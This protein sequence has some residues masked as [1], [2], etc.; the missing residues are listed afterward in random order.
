MLIP[1]MLCKLPLAGRER[2][3]HADCARFDKHMDTLFR[4]T[5]SSNFNT[6]VQALMLIQ[7]LTGT[8]HGSVDRFYRTLYESLLDS[9]LLTSSKQA[10][11]LNLL[12]KSL[13]SDLSIKRVKAFAKRLLQV[14]S[15]HQ[16]AFACGAMYMLRELESSFA[17]LAAS[18]DDRE[19][20]E[21][22]EEEVFQDVQETE[23]D[24]PPPAQSNGLNPPKPKKYPYDGRKRDPEHSNADRACLWEIVSL[25][26]FP[27]TILSHKSNRLFPAPLPNPL[28]PLRLPLR[29]ETPHPRPHA[30][31]TRP[32]IPHPH[33]LPRPLRLPQ[34]QNHHPGPRRIHHATSSSLVLLLHLQQAASA[35]RTLV[36]RQKQA[37]GQL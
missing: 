22:D 31:E 8:H 25:H 30:P 33:P 16:P 26:P 29:A 10:L 1:P 4:V 13:R 18:V 2:C 3:N 14:V 28:S 21:S 19:E 11:Y 20:D 6:S 5:H 12:F 15:M 7:Q 34:P 17:N 24:P 37:A 27:Y 9:R 36:P 23:I 35:D 32:A